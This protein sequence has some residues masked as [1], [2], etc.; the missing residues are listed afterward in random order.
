LNPDHP[1]ANPLPPNANGPGSRSRLSIF[2]IGRNW[3]FTL[4]RAVIWGIATIIIFPHLLVRVQV[5]GPSMLPTC[6]EYSKHWI[7]RCAYL[8]HEP[9]RGDI[10]AIRLAGIHEM[11]LKRIVALP[12]ESIAFSDGRILINGTVLSEPYETNS[13]DWEQSPVALTN[14]EYYV[15]GDNRTMPAQDHYHGICSR[16]RIIGRL[17]K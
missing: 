1:Q 13:C 6:P 16:A 10:V 8:W 7:N 5:V 3:K 4:V 9:Q 11:L 17:L 12:G 15:V 14:G 2:L